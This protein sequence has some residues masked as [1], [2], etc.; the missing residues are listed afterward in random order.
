MS[1]SRMARTSPRA[2]PK[3]RRTASPFPLPV[4]L[5]K[6]S[7]LSGVLL[8]GGEDRGLGAVLRPALDE[9]VLAVRGKGGEPR[10]HRRDVALLVAAG[11]D[12]LTEGSDFMEPACRIRRGRA[13]MPNI[14]ESASTTG[15]CPIQR[16]SGLGDEGM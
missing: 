5:R 9:D 16:F 7:G 2:A 8:D 15:R 3:P 13:I 1:E 4:C 10:H 12:T 11:D 14:R 6:R